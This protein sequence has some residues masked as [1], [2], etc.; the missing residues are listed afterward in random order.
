MF[1]PMVNVSTSGEGEIISDLG[2]SK[3]KGETLARLKK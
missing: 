1:Q 2:I 3:G